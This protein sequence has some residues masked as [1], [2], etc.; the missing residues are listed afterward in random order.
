[1][2]QEPGK[3]VSRPLGVNRCNKVGVTSPRTVALAVKSNSG[4]GE[5]ETFMSYPEYRVSLSAG[6]SMRQQLK[7]GTLEVSA[8]VGDPNRKG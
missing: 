4:K 5:L 3:T 1:M 2:W 6:P 7:T 8:E